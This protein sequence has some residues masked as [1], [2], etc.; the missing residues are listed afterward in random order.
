[1][2]YEMILFCSLAEVVGAIISLAEINRG[3]AS[4][5]SGAAAAGVPHCHL[6]TRAL[7]AEA[8]AAPRASR[9]GACPGQHT[10]TW[11]WHLLSSSWFTAKLQ[12]WKTAWSIKDRCR[13]ARRKGKNSTIKKFKTKLALLGKAGVYTEAHRFSSSS[14]AAAAAATA[15]AHKATAALWSCA[16]IIWMSVAKWWAGRNSEHY[17]VPRRQPWI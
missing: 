14:A 15:T 10:A 7:E 2:F 17:L 11:T 13:K 16:V 4:H 3:K 12:N 5:F 1:M 9:S 8:A 6:A